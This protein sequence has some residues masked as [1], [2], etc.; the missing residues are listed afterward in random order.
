MKCFGILGE[1][2]STVNCREV[3]SHSQ[4]YILRKTDYTKK[5]GACRAP[6]AWKSSKG[7][8]TLAHRKNTEKGQKSRKDKEFVS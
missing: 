7:R 6:A 1:E 2:Y 8:K 3:Q 5:G 4:E